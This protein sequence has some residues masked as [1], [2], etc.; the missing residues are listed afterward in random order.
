MSVS[1][2]AYCSAE[3]HEATQN[4]FSEFNWYECVDDHFIHFC[5]S[6]S[7]FLNA[8]WLSSDSHLYIQAV[9]HEESINHLLYV[10][11]FKKESVRLKHQAL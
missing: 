3:C 2:Y 7:F 9:E 1:E 4:H 5:S 10:S 11:C 8:A 6:F